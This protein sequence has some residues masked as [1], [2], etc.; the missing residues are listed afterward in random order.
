MLA[1]AYLLA[2]VALGD[3]VCRRFLPLESI[4]HR[5]AGAF[6]VGLLLATWIT[7]LAAAVVAGLDQ[8]L[9]VGNLCFFAVTT[10]ALRRM[11]ARVARGIE[12]GGFGRLRQAI[13]SEWRDLAVLGVLLLLGS[14]LM[15]STFGAGNGQ[16]MIGNLVHSDFGSTTALTQSFA[17]GNNFPTVY[18]HFAGEPIRYH[19]LFYFQAGNLGFLG[20]DPGLSLNVLSILSLGA[21]LG[22]IVTLGRLLFRLPII[23]W[24]GATLFFFHGSLVWMPYVS[25]FSTVERA[26][27][28]I[29][30][31]RSF[32]P[33]GF[34]FR[35]EDWGIWSMTVFANQRHFA[36][37]IALLLLVVIFLI[38]RY[39]R[40]GRSPAAPA[41]A[42]LADRL[43][44]SGRRWRQ[45]L[46]GRDWLRRRAGPG[47]P[48]RLHDL[49]WLR[50]RDAASF[51]FAGLLLGA[52]PI[53]NGAVFVAAGALLAGLFLLFP[54]DRRYMLVLAASAAIA[55][56]P[57]VAFL[58]P[59]SGAN[60]A[61]PAFNWGYTLD[62]PTLPNVIWYM[63]IIFG[64][65]LVLATIAFLVVRDLPQRVFLAAWALVAV[66]FAVQFSAEVL[67]NHKFLNIW[68]VIVNLFAAYALVRIWRSRPVAGLMVGRLVAVVFVVVVALGGVI[69]LMPFKNGHMVAVPYDRDELVE[70]VKRNSDPQEVF[71]TD[72]V[73]AHPILTAGRSVYL[74]WPYY[75]WSAG[76]DMPPREE[77]YRRL[78]TETDPR[79]LTRLLHESGIGFVVFD[80]QLFTRGFV[81]NPDETTYRE[82][83]ELAFESPNYRNIRIYRVP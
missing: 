42:S 75:A 51:A 62:D 54:I 30:A 18:P 67:V 12:D 3:T 61:Y 69:D 23:G 21:L 6:L 58:R 77:R 70:W 45:E 72:I 22:L 15:F 56:L 74:G 17:A 49:G 11:P 8:P 71:L 83:F 78:Y 2:M 73:V 52:L 24:L 64:P 80:D 33:T 14:W 27:S 36:S 79:E 65:K 47:Q 38:Q 31:R 37:G 34:P 76:Y 39:R 25:S 32:L 43:R 9:L 16:L 7:Y 48:A 5:A 63:A 53:W 55:G 35:G 20:L 40:A 44:S 50:S 81:E 46:P 13:R 66:A 68:L 60:A 19:F 1:I 57:Q 82:N 41:Q 4:V 59:S 10:V 29:L 28:E 26:V